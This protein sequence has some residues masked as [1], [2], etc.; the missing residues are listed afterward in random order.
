MS[1][2]LVVVFDDET[3]AYEGSRALAE[4]H[5]EGSISAYSGA[6]VARDKDGR[7]SVKEEVDEGPIGTA[8]GMMTGALIGV[9]GGPP[10]VA[11]GAALGTIVGASADLINLGVGVDFV[12][13]VGAHLEPGKVA[14]VGEIE[15]YWTTPVDTRMEELGGTVI[16]RYRIDVED[17]QIERDIAAAKAD[18]QELK[19]ELKAA[20][21]ENKAKLQAKLDA[22]K[23]KLNASSDRAKAKLDSL[24]EEGAAKIKAIEDQVA[25]AQAETKEKLEKRKAELKSDYDRRTGKL[26][27]A[28]EA[29]KEAVAV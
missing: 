15:E 3:K 1:K 28:W 29:T 8:L 25:T 10:G 24:K 14:V 11:V 12:D 16:R 13:E 22:S 9:F 20:N 18:Y 5:R 17:E 23:A 6:I 7:V 2:M 21:E 26:K 4:L 19:A 27:E